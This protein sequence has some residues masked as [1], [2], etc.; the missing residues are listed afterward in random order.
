[1]KRRSFLKRIGMAITGIAFPVKKSLDETK[2]VTITVTGLQP[3][4]DVRYHLI[5]IKK[6]EGDT[7]R[8]FKTSQT[9]KGNFMD[10]KIKE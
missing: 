9:I 6:G 4:D 7:I 5:R 2:E 10:V 3:N 8:E 1:M